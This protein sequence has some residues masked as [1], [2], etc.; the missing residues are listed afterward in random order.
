MVSRQSMSH[1]MRAE[2]TGTTRDLAGRRLGIAHPGEQLGQV[3]VLQLLGPAAGQVLVEVLPGPAERLPQ[4]R[5]LGPQPLG[6]RTAQPL[7]ADARRRRRGRRRCA[8]NSVARV[9]LES[10]AS[11]RLPL[12]PEPMSIVPASTAASSKSISS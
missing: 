4:R 8:G 3:D 6:V 9:T 12:M 11:G 10:W 2:A 7:R 1:F 5:R